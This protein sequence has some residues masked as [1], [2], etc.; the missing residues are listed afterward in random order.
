MFFSFCWD[1]FFVNQ[2][3]SKSTVKAGAAPSF[4]ISSINITKG[5]ITVRHDNAGQGRVSKTLLFAPGTRRI[6]Y[7]LDPGVTN[8][9]PGD[10]DHAASY[11]GS[12]GGICYSNIF[13]E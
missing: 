4:E 1:A 11:T 8:V 3:L 6:I 10:Y 7:S 9:R 2:K 12:G 5:K 13:Y